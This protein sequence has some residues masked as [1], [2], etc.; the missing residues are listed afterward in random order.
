LQLW[1]PVQRAVWSTVA[2]AVSCQLSAP[3]ELQGQKATQNHCKV[4]IQNLGQENTH[5]KT[6]ST[7]GTVPVLGT[8]VDKPRSGSFLG[9]G[10]LDQQSEQ[11]D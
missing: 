9:G 5:R 1:L 10:P 6:L 8:D 2:R 7:C 3:A 11:T 4:V